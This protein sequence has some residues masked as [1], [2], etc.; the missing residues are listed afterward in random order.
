MMNKKIQINTAYLYILP[1]FLIMGGIIVYPVI[2]LIIGS[3]MTVT[4]GKEVF[5]ALRNYRLAFKDPLLWTAL[6]NNLKLFLCVPVMTVLSLVIAVILFNR[7]AGWRF[8]RSIIFL[9]FILAIPVVGI[10][11]TYI[12]Q[13]NGVL[14]TTL[15]NLGL[16]MLA[17]DWLG[18]P[19]LALPSVGA[20][21]IWKQLGFGVVLFLARLMSIDISLYEAAE[22]DG[23]TWLQKFFQVTVPQAA[24][25]IEFYVIISLIDMLSWVFS[26]IF[27]MTAG[28]PGN[29]TT[30]LEFLIYKK[31][32]GGGDFNI[33]MAIS[34]VVLV[35]ATILI[36]IHQSLLGR[37]EE[38]SE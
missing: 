24:A 37:R 6:Q 2:E 26:F 18:S 19:T 9:P 31:S 36:I 17:I 35:M 23:A 4:G 25:V 38:M 1:A 34:A 29:R 32:F 13:M 33:A 22:V 3:F 11:F 5:A 14:N 20:V 7:I 27:V 28:G 21:I 12:L 10:I 15:R 30:V 8:Y 16:D